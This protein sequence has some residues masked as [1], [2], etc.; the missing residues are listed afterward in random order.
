MAIPNIVS[1]RPLEEIKWISE[2]S[3]RWHLL[4]MVNSAKFAWVFS[5]PRV[6]DAVAF[7]LACNEEIKGVGEK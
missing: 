7:R 4:P 5:F 3:I 2:N 1:G 6:Q